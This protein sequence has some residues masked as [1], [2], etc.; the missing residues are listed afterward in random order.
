MPAPIFICQVGQR[1]FYK[2]GRVGFD[3]GNADAGGAYTGTFRSEKISPAGEFGLCQFRKVSF[4]ILRTGAFTMTVKAYVD[5]SQTQRYNSSSVKVDQTV[6][7]AEAAPTN[8]PEE[9]IVEVE[10]D[11]T[12][13]YIEVEVSIVSSQVTGVFLPEEVDVHYRPIRAS[14]QRAGG[15]SQ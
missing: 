7:I 5:G 9:K 14:R 10:I 12:G 3:S 1:R 8:S 11:A 6:V 2:V 4:R 15:E 13:T